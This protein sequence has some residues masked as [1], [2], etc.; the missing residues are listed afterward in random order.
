MS[1]LT[2]N[3]LLCLVCESHFLFFGDWRASGTDGKIEDM[4]TEVTRC[5]GRGC[6]GN[7]GVDVPVGSSSS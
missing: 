5:H 7:L 4:D 1:A 6:A 3:A 2:A